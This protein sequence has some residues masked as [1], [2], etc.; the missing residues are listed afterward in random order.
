MDLG[1]AL[2]TNYMP[3][4]KTVITTRAIAGIDGLKPVQRRILYTMYKMGLLSGNKMKSQ[5]VVG[6]TMKIHPNGDSSIYEAMVLMGSGREQLNVPWIESKGNF[7][8]VY[9]RGAHA[10]ARYTEAKLANV[11]KELFDGINENA[12]DM[13]PN[14]DNSRKEPSLLPVKFPSILVNSSNGIAVGTSSY[15][16]SFG[17]KNV[18]NATIGRLDG[19]INDIPTLAKTLGIPEFTTGGYLHA[20]DKMVEKLCATGRGS[21][22]ISSKAEIYNNRLIITE[23][24]YSTTLEEIADSIGELVKEK[25]ILG[26]QEVKDEIGLNGLR[27]VIEVKKGYNSRDVLKQLYIMTPL[28]ATV[29]FRTRVIVNNRCKE[30]SLMNVIDH[31]IKFRRECVKRVYTFRLNEQTTKEHLL[32]TWEKIK[33]HIKEVVRMIAENTD[34]K[35]K[36]NLKAQY[37]LDDIQAEY[38]LDM[39]IRSITTDKAKAELDKLDKIRED[40]KFSTAIVNDDSVKDKLIISELKEIIEKYGTENKT[41]HV[42]ELKPEDTQKEEIKISDEPVVVMI[43][44]SGY[45][46]R[47][48]A[49]KD[50]ANKFV[51]KNGDEEF[52]R[53]T[54]KNN[55]YLLVFDRFG[56]VHKILV[57]SIDSSTRANL[58]DK[59]TDLA[60]IE[61]LED[62]VWIDACGDY[63][64]YFNLIY[65]NGRGVRVNYS[66]AS[67]KRMKYMSLYDEV[68]RGQF[69]VTTEN[70]FFMITARRKATYVD[71]SNLGVFSTRTAFKV[72]RL[73]SGDRYVKLQPAKDVPNLDAINLSKY[74]KDYTVCIGD[75]VLWMD[76]AQLEA[77]H[78]MMEEEASKY[79][80]AVPNDEDA[81]EDAVEENENTVTLEENVEES[82]SDD[83]DDDDTL[84]IDE[85]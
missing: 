31:W 70:K 76:P 32:A 3:Y 60:G 61:K 55:E 35:A 28:R 59:I 17:L 45:L 13:V 69:W 63:T 34:E 8:K 53:W 7:G 22:T 73:S 75:D 54:I 71:L 82:V 39:K 56:V 78:K 30:L 2:R 12:I 66:K 84:D 68:V 37:G 50:I 29:S 4:A 77:Y 40:I 58:T 85:V 49:L 64:G 42:E 62:I 1:R 15:I 57:D 67:G 26:V 21:F 19:T 38:L 52:R 20:S 46:R 51:A 14:F 72:A 9:S 43:T 25:K 18:C 10:A 36:A 83:T 11:A 79:R 27:L 47:L 81:V 48:T 23:I 5:A 16:P 33:D 24:P 6:E 41:Y 65:P 80:K 44:K 74:Y